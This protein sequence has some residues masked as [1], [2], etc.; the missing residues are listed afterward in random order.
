MAAN[1]WAKV[2]FKDSFAGILS[3]EP[4]GRCRFVYDQS[5]IQNYKT[6][7]SINLPTTKVEH[8]YEN[9]LHPFFDNLVAEGWLAETQ[10]QALS[11]NTNDRFKLLMAFGHDLVG[12][13]SV[14]DPDPNYKIT[15]DKE[16]YLKKTIIQS[17]AS[18]SGVQSKIFVRKEKN[19][20][21]PAEV[22]EFSTH[23]AKLS[24]SYPLLIENEYLCTIAA[25]TLL[26]TD[27]VV[28]LKIGE[29]EGIGKALLVERFDRDQETKTKI[30][31]EEF[32][33][34]LNIKSSQKYNGNYS[35]LADFINQNSILC[36]KVNLEKLFR[37]I[38]VCIL[39][40]NTDAHMKNFA[41]FHTANGLELTPVYDMVFV[42]YYKDLSTRLALELGGDI[43][44]SLGAIKPKHL[45]LLCESFGL[46]PKVLELVVRDFEYRLDQVYELI[47]V[48]KQI[49]SMLRTALLD[50]VKKRWNGTFKT[51][52][53][54]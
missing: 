51:I 32:A 38:L 34:L 39:L 1:N 26:S 52:G 35:D 6:G 42:S 24:G 11:I 19:K 30:H 10:A 15:L 23:I 14:I 16:S 44:T 18:M 45:S 20:F 3:E 7:I 9:G 41:M 54:K 37:R 36:S 28:D 49:P 53:K 17:K 4:G 2:Y 25:K 5:F 13:V 50:Q 40:G 22:D 8:I 47:N 46:N 12:A 27:Q 43:D 48:Q 33:Q 29:V 31:F 21:Y